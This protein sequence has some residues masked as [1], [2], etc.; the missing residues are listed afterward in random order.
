MLNSVFTVPQVSVGESKEVRESRPLCYIVSARGLQTKIVR[1]KLGSCNSHSFRLKSRKSGATWFLGAL[2]AKVWSPNLKNCYF[3]LLI[4]GTLAVVVGE[5]L[6][7]SCA[8]FS[9]PDCIPYNL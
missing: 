5:N 7:S 8:C 3:I 6:L 9:I 2:R 1:G 4:G